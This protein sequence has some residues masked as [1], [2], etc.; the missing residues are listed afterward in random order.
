MMPETVSDLADKVVKIALE[1]LESRLEGPV[2]T[3]EYVTWA[4]FCTSD[5]LRARVEYPEPEPRWDLPRTVRRPVMR[6]FARQSFE[7]LAPQVKAELLYRT[8]RFYRHLP[9]GGAEYREVTE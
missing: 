4:V 6:D 8:Y 5:G 3:T 7:P 1:R 2:V 9:G